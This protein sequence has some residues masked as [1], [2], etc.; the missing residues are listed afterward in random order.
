MVS[1]VLFALV[2]FGLFGGGDCWFVWRRMGD[3]TL[4]Y[5]LLHKT[6]H[7]SDNHEL[8]PCRKASMPSFLHRAL[9]F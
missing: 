7:F 4:M 1:F 2:I 6:V 5:P 9:D 8:I 3:R